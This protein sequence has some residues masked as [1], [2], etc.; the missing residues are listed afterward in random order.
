MSEDKTLIPGNA[1]THGSP[2]PYDQR[3]PL[4]FFG[5]HIAKGHF[6][7]T[8]SP[9]DIA[10]TLSRITGVPLPTA[11]GRVLKEALPGQ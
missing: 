3:V 9:A 8:C 7:E 6:T 10:P 2:Y 4:V 5:D 11:T 1:T